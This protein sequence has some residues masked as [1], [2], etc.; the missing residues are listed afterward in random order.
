MAKG[1]GGNKKLKFRTT[2]TEKN[3][4]KKKI[5][6][7]FVAV[8]L[9]V[10][11]VSLTV[12]IKEYNLF[13]KKTD[14]DSK[15][16][17]IETQLQD[18]VS[19]LFAGASNSE[20]QLT[21]LSVIN[22]DT[23]KQKFKVI[24]L[25]PNEKFEGHTLTEIYA[26][27][28]ADTMTKAAGKILDKKIDRYAVITEKKFKNFILAIGYPELNIPSDIEYESA[29]FSLS[30]LKGK[31][32]MSGDK[33][34]K[35]LRYL[36]I[37]DTDYALKQQSLVVGELVAKRLNEINMKKGDDLFSTVIN[38]FDSNITIMDFTKYYSLFCEIAKEPRVVEAVAY[39]GE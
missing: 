24:A 31:Q 7:L 38:N 13:G 37:G 34:Y 33:L 23:D 6:A 19:I 27:S 29:E 17:A 8:I 39:I 20:D 3:A 5:I 36:G 25:S 12:L 32:N 18:E 26:S 22:L 35:Y 30:L 1:I 4:K 28:D 16:P 21:F 10:A 15:K 14:G 2:Q 11:A 9:I